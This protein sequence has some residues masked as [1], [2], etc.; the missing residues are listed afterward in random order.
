[1]DKS[2]LDSAVKFGIE[3]MA[4]EDDLAKGDVKSVLSEFLSKFTVSEI[5]DSFNYSV[6]QV[7]EEKRCEFDEFLGVYRSE[8]LDDNMSLFSDWFIVEL[9]SEEFIGID[10]GGGTV[11]CTLTNL[12]TDINEREKFQLSKL[13]TLISFL[14]SI[15]YK[16]K[17]LK[18][19][20]GESLESW[21]L[22]Y[23]KINLN[24]HGKLIYFNM[25]Y[26]N[27]TFVL[28]SDLVGA[29][30]SK[31]QE[32]KVNFYENRPYLYYYHLLSFVEPNILVEIKDEVIAY[33]RKTYSKDEFMA[34]TLDELG[35]FFSKDLN[36]VE[37]ARYVLFLDINTVFEKSHQFEFAKLIWPGSDLRMLENMN[38]V[39]IV[40]KIKEI[41]PEFLDMYN[42]K[43]N[44][45]TKPV[46]N[47][48]SLQNFAYVLGIEGRVIDKVPFWDLIEKVYGL[49]EDS[50]IDMGKDELL[51]KFQGKEQFLK[52]PLKDSKFNL[53]SIGKGILAFANSVLS[54][55]FRHFNK[56]CRELLADWLWPEN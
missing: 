21:K 11:K 13:Q 1:M 10:A 32:Y 37:F 56:N 43:S 16:S 46:F 51:F 6:I 44:E 19:E 53:E 48:Y 3:L 5:C 50:L 45:R 34:F 33:F 25:A 14:E 27:G 52:T 23:V 41:Y 30:K 22:P 8:V 40:E 17:E 9:V 26:H 29:S 47:G 2:L 49:N 15:G 4:S 24:N 36:L 7:L 12:E 39:E 28:D 54:E 31:L 18:V 35:E 42:L 55:N 38:E 20:I